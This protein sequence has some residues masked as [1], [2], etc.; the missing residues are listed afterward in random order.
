VADEGVNGLWIP[1]RFR[2]L[3]KTPYYP[4][5]PQAERRATRLRGMLGLQGACET[6]AS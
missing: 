5:N 2:E 4:E 6:S 3:A 1:V